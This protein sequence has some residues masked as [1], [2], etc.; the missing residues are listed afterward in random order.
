[1]QKNQARKTGNIGED[2]VCD[3]LI[4]HGY[5]ILERNFTVRG[6]EIDIVAYKK[7]LEVIAFVEVKT[8]GKNPL[9][10]GEE[11]ITKAKKNHIIKTAEIFCQRKLNEPCS[12]R[13]DVAVVQVSD[14]SVN[15]LKYYVSAFDASK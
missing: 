1:M 6:G 14:K 7:E 12:C 13:F 3:F 10:S 11:A 5:E 8:R 15:R 4:R 9:V 2:A